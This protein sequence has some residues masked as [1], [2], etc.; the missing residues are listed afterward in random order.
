[1][2]SVENQTLFVKQLINKKIMDSSVTGFTS[3]LTNQDDNEE[4]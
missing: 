3:E 2:Y 4:G 1:L